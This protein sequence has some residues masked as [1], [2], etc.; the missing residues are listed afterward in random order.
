MLSVINAECSQKTIYA[1]CHLAGCLYAKC[2]YTECHGGADYNFRSLII[3]NFSHFRNF[4]FLKK[5]LHFQNEHPNE[6]LGSGHQASSFYSF[7]FITN[8]QFRVCTLKHFSG[9]IYG[10]LY[11]ARVFVPGK[12]FQPSLLFV[13][14]ARGLQ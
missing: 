12:P 2:R 9:V 1:E 11:E 13:G 8:V 14:K 4:E 3:S 6:K 7:I 5:K 10:F